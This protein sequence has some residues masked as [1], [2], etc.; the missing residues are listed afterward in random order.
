MHTKP[1]TPVNQKT[2][3]YCNDTSD[4]P[5]VDDEF[6]FMMICKIF[7]HERLS[8]FTRANTENR[9]YNDLTLVEK[10]KTLMCPVTAKSTKSVHRFIKEVFKKRE[11][12]ISND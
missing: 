3:M 8:L 6:H 2:C 1:P 4:Q 10:F 5:Y 9:F 11:K 7:E 12:I